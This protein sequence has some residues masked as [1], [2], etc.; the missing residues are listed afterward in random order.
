MEKVRPWCGP[1]SDRGQLKNR[2]GTS[3]IRRDG[4]SSDTHVM[5]KTCYVMLR[6]IHR[7]L[8]LVDSLRLLLLPVINNLGICTVCEMISLAVLCLIFT[9][10]LCRK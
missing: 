9:A 4:C 5:L 8:L 7:Q 10:N 1:P 3:V 6:A 2:T